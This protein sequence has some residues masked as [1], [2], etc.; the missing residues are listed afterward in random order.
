MSRSVRA[1]EACIRAT[2]SSPAW[3]GADPE[4]R[5]RLL[6][7]ALC[8]AMHTRTPIRIPRASAHRR[9]EDM[10][11]RNAAV[12]RQF[13]GRNYAALALAHGLTER[14]IRRIVDTPRTRRRAQKMTQS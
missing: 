2:L 14:Q 5:I 1:M 8:D 7:D 12:R 11:R 4:A 9:H 3:I 10:R 13:D 6:V